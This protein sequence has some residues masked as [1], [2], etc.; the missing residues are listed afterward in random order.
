MSKR[1][2]IHA[3]FILIVGGV[4]IAVAV[5]LFLRYKRERA[6]GALPPVV[7]TTQYNKTL[8]AGGA[9]YPRKHC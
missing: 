8:M 6:V 4:V 1:F 3:I 7:V 5:L 2:R 9:D